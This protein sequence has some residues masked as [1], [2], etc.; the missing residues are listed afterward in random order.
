MGLP[1]AIR[2]IALG[3]EIF[4]L[5]RSALSILAVTLLLSFV[6]WEAAD[7][8]GRYLLLPHQAVE[9]RDINNSADLVDG[10]AFW[11]IHPFHKKIPGQL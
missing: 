4:I 3:M 1:N 9:Q 7:F 6:A 11:K 8:R 5:N 2:P 10:L